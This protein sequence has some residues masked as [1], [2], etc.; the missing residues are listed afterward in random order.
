MVFR[1]SLKVG[2]FAPLGISHDEWMRMY[3]NTYAYFEHIYI[4]FKVDFRE[5]S[6]STA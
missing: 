2:E 5:I 1:Y 4:L 3:L 6:R